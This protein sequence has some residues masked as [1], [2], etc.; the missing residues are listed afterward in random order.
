MEEKENKEALPIFSVNMCVFAL[1]ME[2]G[3][4]RYLPGS[5]WRAPTCT[6]GREEA[7]QD[8]PGLALLPLALQPFPRPRCP[9]LPLSRPLQSPLNTGLHLSQANK[10]AGHDFLLLNSLLICH[11]VSS[12]WG[13]PCVCRTK[14]GETLSKRILNTYDPCPASNRKGYILI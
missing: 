14:R 11:A 7:S 2:R 5:C 6:F 10:K 4:S 3:R 13:Q 8:G 12:V 1:L 9:W